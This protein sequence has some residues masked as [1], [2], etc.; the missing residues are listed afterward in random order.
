MTVED[1]GVAERIQMRKWRVRMMNGHDGICW[2]PASTEDGS[3]FPCPFV[4]G[5]N[6]G[7]TVK[8]EPQG[9]KLRP[10]DMQEFDKQT[11]I[12]RQA[13]VNSAAALGASF[14]NYKEYAE[15]I[16]NWVT[17]K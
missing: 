16:F 10:M 14:D 7:Y 17:S 6:C 8:E 2:T 13:C 4:K 5:R 1:M 15:D 9:L 12:T 11:L 3:P